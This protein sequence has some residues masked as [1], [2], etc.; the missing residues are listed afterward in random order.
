MHSAQ[1]KKL[2][3]DEI[4]AQTLILLREYRQ[5]SADRPQQ[6]KIRNAIANLNKGLPLAAAREK[7]GGDVE[8]RQDLYQ[9]GMIGLLKAIAGFNLSRDVA[10]SSYAMKFI[11]GEISHYFRDNAPFRYGLRVGRGYKEKY[12]LVT[13]TQ[14]ILRDRGKD[15]SLPEVAKLCLVSDWESVAAANLP[16]IVD[17]VDSNDYQEIIAATAE[18]DDLDAVRNAIAL[19][20]DHQ[21]NLIKHHYIDGWDIPKLAQYYGLPV[22][23]VRA[24][25]RKA[26]A[27]IREEVTA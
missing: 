14:K 21:Q 8:L 1:T 18:D 24:L 26:I 22:I 15:L 10:F 9:I 4:K 19:L 11:R 23:A 6:I 17:S 12:G 2:S 3:T 5:L 27:Q 16:G 7:D 13:K 20:P 25:L